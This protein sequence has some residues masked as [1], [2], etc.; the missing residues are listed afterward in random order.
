MKLA[1]QAARDEEV[2]SKIPANQLISQN[3]C[4]SYD[5]AQLSQSFLRSIRYTQ[6]F[7]HRNYQLLK[8]WQGLYGCQIASDFRGM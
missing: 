3:R 8:I 5:S 7:A 2:R 1:S 6:A 4:P